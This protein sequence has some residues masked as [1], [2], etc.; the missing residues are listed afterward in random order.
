MNNVTEIVMNNSL[1]IDK[2]GFLSK[3]IRIEYLLSEKS[4]KIFDVNSK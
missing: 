1:F 2:V 3:T 4:N